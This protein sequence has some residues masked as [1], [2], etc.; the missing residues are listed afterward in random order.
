MKKS[1]FFYIFFLIFFIY[2]AISAKPPNLL[3]TIYIQNNSNFFSSLDKYY[4]K[5]SDEIPYYFLI[6]CDSSNLYYSEVKNNLENYPNLTVFFNENET[7][8]L[9]Y[10]KGIHKFIDWFD[11][12]FITEDNFEPFVNQYDK[13]ITNA[14]ISNYPDFDGIL[15]FIIHS[16]LSINKTPV[17]GKKYYERLGYVYHPDYQ[18]SFYDYELTYVSRILGKETIINQS[19]LT[20]LRK[21]D[22]PKAELPKTFSYNVNNDDEIFAERRFKTFDIDDST[23]KTIFT[24]D[25]S[26]LICTLSEREKQFSQLYSNLLKQIQDNNLIDKIEVLFFKDNRELSIG[27]K[28]N[29]LLKKSKGMF[30]NFIDDDDDIRDNYIEMIYEKLKTNPDCISLSGIITFNGSYPTLFIHSIKYNS[31]FASN[32]IFYRPPNHLNTIK[33]SIASQFLFPNISFG[34]DTDWALQ[35]ARSNLLKKEEEITIPYY[36]YNYIPN[37]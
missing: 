4:Q 28:R 18:S 31:Y 25:W 13:I 11:I 23:L 32:G 21:A 35:I 7:K 20:D 36:Y 16:N 8:T 12:L 26:I 2:H 19:I 34:E 3:I 22:L 5:L 27:D 1:L 33:R 9:G 29:A 14:M 37:K 6:I 15:N 30:I 10:N 17:I 24:K